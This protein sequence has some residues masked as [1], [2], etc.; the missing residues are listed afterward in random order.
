MALKTIFLF[1][2]FCVVMVLHSIGQNVNSLFSDAIN[3]GIINGDSTAKLQVQKLQVHKIFITGNNK[4]KTYII[5]REIQFK[6]GDSI[7][8]EH[9]LKELKK[10]RQQVYNTN[11]FN[12]VKI[13]PVI[14][15]AY[16]MDINVEV[17]ERWYIYPLPQFK[18]IDRNFN[19][20]WKTYHRDFSRANYG[21]K[22]N[23]Y[24]LTGK[25][26]AL[27][28][29]F[30]T[31]YTRA[32]LFSYTQP[33]S[34]ASLTEGF[35][36]SANF[37]Q[38]R[39]IAYGTSKQNISNLYE[40]KDFA[41][42]TFGGSVTYIY[43]KAIKVRHLWRIAYL[44]VA[45]ADTVLKLNKTYFSSDSTA[46][47]SSTQN[48]IDLSYS[49]RFADVDKIAYPLKGKTYSLNILKRGLGLTSK[50]NMLS[51]EA[52]YNR[53]W[54]IRKNL[55]SD[56]SLYGKIKLPFEEAYINQRGLGYGEN[57]LRG[58]QHYVIDGV[59][60]GY[61][62]STLKTKVLGFTVP[63]PIKS[64]THKIIP[65]NFYAKAFADFGGVYNKSSSQY[66]LNNTLLYTCGAG[67]D[68]LTLYDINIGAEYCFNQLNQ[69]GL[70]LHAQ[71][72]F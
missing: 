41:N 1:I 34:N 65:F 27:E 61:I 19:E 45:V 68:M 56:I 18:L 16:Q 26:D 71:L 7:V 5:S 14:L 35:S 20:W 3:S 22:F 24:N 25:K 67:V 29:N 53:Y 48:I 52:I 21:L 50:L 28:I 11:L 43:R 62:K 46:T 4:T 37:I 38:S 58:L 44:N 2:C 31:G 42:T 32:V 30:L 39:E 60:M 72:G 57:Y 66:R 15:S 51:L 6:E 55:Y 13:E 8:I 49:Y 47:P 17:K 36:V 10:A 23:H 12:E 63:F 54:E 70:F 33:N 40:G 64:A 59:A 69:N 9:L